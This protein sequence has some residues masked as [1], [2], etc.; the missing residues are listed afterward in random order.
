MKRLPFFE[1]ATSGVRVRFRH[2]Q[3]DWLTLKLGWSGNRTRWPDA[4]E[5][6]WGREDGGL[7]RLL[8]ASVP[9]SGTFCPFPKFIAWLEAM[10]LG[11]DECGFRWDGEGPNGWLRWLYGMLEIE[12]SGRSRYPAFC[13]RIEADRR[14]VVGAFYQAFRGFVNSSEYRP[15][16]YESMSQGEFLVLRTGF[17]PDELIGQLLGLDAATA[18][19]W[20]DEIGRAH[21]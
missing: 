12:W 7:P 17:T 11:C 21:V 5:P 15:E 10:A 18:G 9:L 4:K 2:E 16:S 6:H 3:Y 13:H 19:C 8:T 20:L 14:Q 1:H